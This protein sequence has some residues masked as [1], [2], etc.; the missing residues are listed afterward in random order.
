MCFND[1]GDGS[2]DSDVGSNLHRE[3]GA[4]RPP[5]HKNPESRDSAAKESRRKY[6]NSG[7]WV[8]PR[9]SYH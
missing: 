1:V 3:M 2:G 9:Y 6:D 8:L 7:K 4:G 5:K